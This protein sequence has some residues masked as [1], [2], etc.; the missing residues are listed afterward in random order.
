M[1]TVC[2]RAR[3]RG[4]LPIVTPTAER[5]DRLAQRDTSIGEGVCARVVPEGQPSQHARRFELSQTGGEHVRRHA[6]IPLQI[7]VPLRSV[8]EP[9][10]DEQR[11]PGS[12]DVEGC[13][14]VAQER[15]SESGFIQNGE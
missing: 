13:G 8:E 9:F 1:F 4:D 7:A 12:D 5:I 15:G 2:A 3:P 6:E 11:P 10:D 14:K